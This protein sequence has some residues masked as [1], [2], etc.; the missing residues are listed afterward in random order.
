MARAT[1]RKNSATT[2]DKRAGGVTRREFARQA[3]AAA[4]IAA[5]P[6]NIALHEKRA[7]ALAGAPEA[8]LHPV[9]TLPQETAGSQPKLSAEAL[10]E[11]EARSA[12]ILRRY[13]AKLTE[14][15]KADVRR[16]AREAQ[17][18]LE[19]LRRFPLENKD[20]PATVLRVVSTRPVTAPVAAGARKPAGKGA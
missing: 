5:L 4:A 1:R 9:P 17:V 10:A 14:E 18:P 3:A 12:E 7:A 11:A 6:G 13:G 16:L 19:A 20:E 15:Q 2:L 8:S